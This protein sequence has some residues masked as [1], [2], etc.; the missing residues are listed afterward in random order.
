MAALSTNIQRRLF[1]DVGADGRYEDSTREPATC[2]VTARTAV[3]P[4]RAVPAHTRVRSPRARLTEPEVAVALLPETASPR[5]L[6]VEDDPAAAGAIRAALELD[7]EPSWAIDIAGGGQRALELASAAPP[8]VV[9][10]DVGLPDV[11]GAEVYRSLRAN[12]LTARA[13][14]LFL[15]GKTSLDL[16]QRGIDDGVLLRKPFDPRTLAGLV[17]TLLAA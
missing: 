8:E 3:R 6:I 7:G 1:E 11:D 4:R 10:L 5:I 12:P 17:R 16:Y 2:E 15:S 14:V 13:R 9:L